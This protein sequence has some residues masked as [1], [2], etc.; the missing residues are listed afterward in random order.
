MVDFHTHILPAV[1]DGS[2]QIE[3]SLQMLECQKNQGVRKV[4]LTP[5]FYPRTDRLDAFLERRQQAY[6]QLCQASKDRGQ[7]PELIL[8]AEVAYYRGIGQSDVLKELTIGGTQ[9]LLVEMPFGVWTDAMYQELESLYRLQGI[10]PILAHLDRYLRVFHTKRILKR[11]ADLP[12]LVQVNAQFFIGKRTRRTALKLFAQ[13]SIDLLGSDCHNLDR[14]PPCLK[15]AY[16]VI[17]AHFG[18]DA[19]RHME[20]TEDNIL[21]T[22]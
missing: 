16:D 5:H 8:G 10:V 15:E 6:D 18:E 21:K 7:L 14:R 11:L 17:R 13:G 19:I 3:Q 22:I 20:E 1:D 12:V 2:K 4:V 9:Y